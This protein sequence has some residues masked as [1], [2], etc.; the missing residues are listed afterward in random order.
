MNLPL[1]SRLFGLAIMALAAA[2]APGA[3]G[4]PPE[5]QRVTVRPTP[6]EAFRPTPLFDQHDPSNV[7]RH[8]DRYWV[9]V[10]RNRHDHQDVTVHA[11]SSPD[12]RQWAYT[13]EAIGRGAAGS[14]DE[15]GAIAPFCVR[16]GGK[17]YLFY[18]GFR[19]GNLATR[20]LGC[21]IADHPAGPWVR[22]RGNP[23]LRRDPSPEAWDSGM[24]GDSNVF[25]R[26]G[27]WW[28]Y[29]KSRR[30]RESNQETRIG[31]AFADAIT[32]PYR[33]HPGN[34]LFVGHAFSA[35]PHRD[36]VAALCGVL[37]PKIQWSTDGLHFV[38]A[39]EFPNQSTGLF[40]P[41]PADDPRHRRGFDWGLEVYSENGARGLRRFD[42]LSP[43]RP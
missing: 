36:G 13:G 26:E 16:H 10:T 29:F 14:W 20:D 43:L 34:P 17:F 39:G 9:F 21:A 32:G 2:A 28:L 35:W 24:L 27:R 19:Q 6:I 12:G 22:W 40:T 11:A 7:L 8:E 3:D 33:K 23:V 30:D 31:V 18:T 4:I 25:F 37:S 42:C 38:D 15:S 1:F 41:D 5:L